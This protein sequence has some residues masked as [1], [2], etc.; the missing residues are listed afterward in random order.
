M[1]DIPAEVVKVIDAEIKSKG[2]PLTR[3][4]NILNAL[5]GAHI[6]YTADL[7]VEEVMVH[8]AN[9]GYLGLNWHRVH[10]LGDKIKRIGAQ[11]KELSK[12]T[13]FER[14]PGPSG[15]RQDEKNREL[16]RQADGQLAPWT[17]K[18]RMCS[19][20]SGHTTAFCRA[21]LAGCQTKIETLKDSSGSINLNE[22]HKDNEFKKMLTEGWT[23]TVIPARVELK[24]P[25]LPSIAEQALNVTNNVANVQT[26]LE[27]ACHMAQMVHHMGEQHWETAVQDVQATAPGCSEYV[28]LIAKYTRLYGGGEQAPMIKF[29]D[30][31]AKQFAG[32]RGP[33][34]KNGWGCCL[35]SCSAF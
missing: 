11:K 18:E 28:D 16:I 33:P 32:T 6:A 23:W 4:H 25:I 3:W 29:L 12:S 10:A 34:A 26:E 27:V 15:D 31:F 1:A 30:E 13:C 14:L 22:L 20:A 24:W 8:P 5:I 35:F 2:P 17:G 19:V 7:K 21:A 9:R